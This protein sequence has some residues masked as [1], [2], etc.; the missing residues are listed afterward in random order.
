MYFVNS[1][2]D[3]KKPDVYVLPST[4]TSLGKATLKNCM[5]LNTTLV[6]PANM[7][8]LDEDGWNFG[9]RGQS[10]TRNFVF[11]GEFTELIFAN[12]N[13]NTNFYYI[14]PNMKAENI[15]IKFSYDGTSIPTNCYVFVC[16][17]GKSIKLDGASDWT[18]DGYSHIVNPS[19]TYQTEPD[20][21]TGILEI[22]YCYCG[23][24]IGE[25]ELEN[26]ALGHEYSLENGATKTVIEYASYL[27][28]GN[29]KI[30]CARCDEHSDNEV[31]PIIKEFKGISIKEKGNGLTFGY[32]INY[33]ALDE[34]VE[35]NKTSVSLGFVVAVQAFL[36][37]NQPLTES[38]E[39]AGDKVVKL[40]IYN[41]STYADKGFRYT[42]VD[43]KLMGNW[44]KTVD[45]DGDGEAETDIKDVVFYMAGY[46][47]DGDTASFI[48]YGA[49]GKTSDAFSY[50]Q[51]E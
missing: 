31:A 9:N 10:T 37:E 28:K 40:E 34:Y 33:D 13:Y 7:K 47:I 4:L 17:E 42:G 29:L 26:S 15:E 5:S 21:V 39:K 50:N 38:G 6:F 22:T 24:K 41:S 44:S 19:L 14:N 25:T 8:N 2:Q 32:V 16:S 20:C 11:L 30:K 46:I 35:V 27:A 12:E 49:T 36:G 18:E 3:T 23:A 45:L 43:F 48:N 1:P 51:F